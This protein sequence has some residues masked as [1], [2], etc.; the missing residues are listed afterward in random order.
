MKRITK[1]RLFFVVLWCLGLC[2]FSA[3]SQKQQ[4]WQRMKKASSIIHGDPCDLPFYWLSTDPNHRCADL[5]FD[6][7]IN[8]FDYAIYLRMKNG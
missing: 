6:N 2:V 7:E 3:A 5:N 4:Q 8:F 1:I